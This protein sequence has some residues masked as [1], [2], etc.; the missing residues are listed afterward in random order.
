MAP[1]TPAGWRMTI[2]VPMRSSAGSS[3]AASAMVSNTD[4]ARPTCTRTEMASG[5]PTSRAM[6]SASSA[7]RA[8][9]P[10]AIAVTASARSAMGTCAHASKERRAASTAR[11]ASDASPAG[12]VPMMSVVAASSTVSTSPVEGPTHAPS[13][14]SSERS[15]TVPPAVDHEGWPGRYRGC[16]G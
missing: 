16:R 2:D 14:Y 9:R 8:R 1:T 4:A 11:S 13:M 6:I 12:T 3:R 10:A 5:V 15:I 7:S